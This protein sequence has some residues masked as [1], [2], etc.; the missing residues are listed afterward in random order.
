MGNENKDEN[1]NGMGDEQTGLRRR[2]LHHSR[3]DDGQ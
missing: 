1:S 2:R 3:D